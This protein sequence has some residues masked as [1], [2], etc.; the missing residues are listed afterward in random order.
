MIKPLIKKDDIA[1]PLRKK[2]CIK[3]NLIYNTTSF[4][5]Y[6]DDKTICSNLLSFRADL[7]KFN[8]IKLINLKKKKKSA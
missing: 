2:N 6:C 4:F 8:M 5:G 7:E 3:Q 1:K